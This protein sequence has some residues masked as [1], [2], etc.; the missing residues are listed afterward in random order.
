MVMG[1]GVLQARV[2]LCSFS[3]VTDSPACISCSEVH[4]W[5]LVHLEVSHQILGQTMW[6]LKIREIKES[7]NFDSNNTRLWQV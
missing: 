5:T 1:G 2:P 3:C 6:S 7:M 4:Y